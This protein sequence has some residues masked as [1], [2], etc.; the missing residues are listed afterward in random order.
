MKGG[1]K[2]F[3]GDLVRG[4]GE[5]PDRLASGGRGE[6]LQS[7]LSRD[8]TLRQAVDYHTRE[9]WNF[10]GYEEALPH[11]AGHVILGLALNAPPRDEHLSA[12]PYQGTYEAEIYNIQIEHILNATVTGRFKAPYNDRQK[13]ITDVLST[14]REFAVQENLMRTLGWLME[15]QTRQSYEAMREEVHYSDAAFQDKARA[16]GISINR[17]EDLKSWSVTAPGFEDA[18][19]YHSP[20]DAI[21]PGDL[22]GVEDFARFERPHVRDICE[23]YDRVLPA[24]HLLQNKAFGL[25]RSGHEGRG[26]YQAGDDVLGETKVRDLYKAIVNRPGN[27]PVPEWDERHTIS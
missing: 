17:S 18:F 13:F 7:M 26:Y 1:F 12:R 8:M 25:E 22:E 10:G 16:M 14:Y 20:N 6:E 3:F 2:K 21:L 11:E 24:I 4:L 9:V 15:K 19:F 27:E 23:I 5:A